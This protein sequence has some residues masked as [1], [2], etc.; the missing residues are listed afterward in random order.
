LILKELNKEVGGAAEAMGNTLPGAMGKLK[1]AFDTKLE[2]TATA[3]VNMLTDAVNAT[4]D[5]A[6]MTAKIDD[7]LAEHQAEVMK[8]AKTYQEYIDEQMRAYIVSNQAGSAEMRRMEA[9]GAH[10]SAL[11]RYIDI[12]GDYTEATWEAIR[13]VDPLID[14]Y[15]RI[16]VAVEETTLVYGPFRDATD[17]ATVA[18]GRLKDTQDGLN[19]AFGI[20]KSVIDDLLISIEQKLRLEEQLALATGQVTQAELDQQKATEAIVLGW[21]SGKIGAEEFADVMWRISSGTWSTAQAMEYVLSL[22]GRTSNVTFTINGQDP[23]TF[24]QN[25]GIGAGW[26]S[27][28]VNQTVVVPTT[29]GSVGTPATPAAPGAGYT[30]GITPGQPGGGIQIYVTVPNEQTAQAVANRVAQIIGGQ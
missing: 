2:P 15:S 28:A 8:T 3:L 29:P 9:M 20:G 17:D 23:T 22:N 1:T 10:E 18:A 7:V 12:T 13:A 24:Y 26:G 25:Y 11:Q 5:L 6:T 16:K 21:A 14:R 19:S 27:G 30:P 4:N